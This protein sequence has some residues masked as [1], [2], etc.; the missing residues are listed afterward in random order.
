MSKQ[1]ITSKEVLQT[2][3]EHPEYLKLFRTM[4][5][6]DAVEELVGEHLQREAAVQIA[7]GVMK[8]PVIQLYVASDGSIDGRE[9]ME[10]VNETGTVSRSAAAE[11]GVRSLL[12][13]KLDIK[14]LLMIVALMK[15]FSGSNT[16][17][18]QGGNLISSLLG[19]ALGASHSGNSG[20]QGLLG[21]LFGAGS[22]TSAN[23]MSSLGLLGAL[24]G[25]GM[26]SQANSGSH[27]A[28]G[29]SSGSQ[30]LLGSLLSG[31]VQPQ[32]YQ[33]PSQQSLLG[34]LL[35]SASQAQSQ[36]VQ[37]PQQSALGSLLNGSVNQSLA[38]TQNSYGMNGQVYALDG[39]APQVLNNGYNVNSA[40]AQQIQSLLSGS[41]SIH[42]NGQVNVGN[43][44]SIAS[45]LL[46][47]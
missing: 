34:A 6:V 46:G 9:L 12:D 32:T 15:L 13:G 41:D 28:Y 7:K 20:S 27:S 19:S 11:Q 24:L 23:T 17:S 16:Q 42:D 30:S 1:N 37:Q 26:M 10:F 40:Q 47:K 36:P 43:L 3:R 4:A 33:Q 2:L 45:A 18:N 22:Q 25:A 38:Q 31:A 39:T 14:T 21:S 5:A 44:F 29:Q 8:D 35:S